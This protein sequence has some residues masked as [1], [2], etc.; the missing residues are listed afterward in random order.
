MERINSRDLNQKKSANSEGSK[1][2]LELAQRMEIIRNQLTS[3]YLSA[4]RDQPIN[5]KLEIEVN[6]ALVDWEEIPTEHLLAVCTDARRSSGAFM[7]SNGLVVEVWREMAA[8][9]RR[10]KSEPYKA[11]PAVKR[12]PEEIKQIEDMCRSVRESLK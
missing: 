9:A 8:E 4:R 1:Q 6:L 5:E 7:A 3:F 10:P 11:L 2:T 12:T